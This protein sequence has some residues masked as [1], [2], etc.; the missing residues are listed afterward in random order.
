MIFRKYFLALPLVFLLMPFSVLFSQSEEATNIFE[1]Y[2]QG[3]ITFTVYDEEDEEIAQGSGFLIGEK[4][5]VTSY[6]LVCQANEAE[7]LDYRGKKVK[8]DGILSVDKEFG[9]ALVQVNR[10]DPILALGNSDGLDRSSELYAIGGNEVGEISFSEGEVFNFHQIKS[11]RLIESSLSIPDEYNGAPVFD[12][13]GQVVGMII[14][15]DIGKNIIVPSNIIKN[16]P[17]TKSETK[18]KNWQKENY[19]STLEGAYFAAEA[20]YALND[21]G[22]AEKFLKKVIELKPND[23]HAYLLLASVYYNQ[24]AYSSALT[25]YQKII[26]LNPN[27]DDAHFGLGLVNLKMMKWKEA[28]PPLKRAVQLNQDN[29]EAYLH[30]GTAHQELQEFEEA[31]DAYKQYLNTNPNQPWDVY[32][33][34]GVCQMEAGEYAGA[35]NSFNK[36]L[37]GYGDD[38]TILYKLAQ[39]YEK[40]GQID[41]AAATYEKLAQITPEDAKRYYNMVIMMYNTA[42]MPEKAAEVAKKLV[43]LDPNDTEALYNL[44][45]MYVQMENYESAIE[46]FSKVIEKSPGMEYAHLQLGYSYTQL[47]QYAK[48]AEAYKNMVEIFPNNEDAWFGLGIAYMQ[49]KKYSEGVEPL[50]KVIELNPSRAYAYY[51]LAI[52]YLNLRDNY[53]AREIYNQLN[54]VDPDLAKKLKQYIK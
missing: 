50:K 25:T 42:K 10:K 4:I 3:V 48:A 45:Y 14:F 47:K 8:F 27:R 21:T 1:N 17:Q 15:L 19:F 9:I 30:I 2:K 12:S 37:E 54:K 51:N 53:S 24:R 35:V 46:I 20:F 5:L 32:T 43:E 36:A 7:G 40:A 11:R 38:I 34:L 13:T 23:L 29:K 18:F 44:G 33:Q 6:G 28:I 49:Q 16:L 22:K 26:E 39:A 31:I 52:S 41:Q